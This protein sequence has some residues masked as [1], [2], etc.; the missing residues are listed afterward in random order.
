M[1]LNK[2]LIKNNL[3]DLVRNSV[4]ETYNALL[5]H[6]PDELANADKR[7]IKRH[8]RAVEASPD[9][10][11]ALILVCARLHHEVASDWDS[12]RYLNMNPLFEQ[13]FQHEIDNFDAKR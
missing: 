5:D 10:Q 4:E 13:E 2:D 8:T 6:E 3:K 1:Q 11:S 9:W 7:E 12:K